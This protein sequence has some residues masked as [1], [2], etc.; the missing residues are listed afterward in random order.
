MLQHKKKYIVSITFLLILAGPTTA[1]TP[2]HNKDALCQSVLQC[3]TKQ[4]ILSHGFVPVRGFFR[5]DGSGYTEQY[6][7]PQVRQGSAYYARQV[8]HGLLCFATLGL[9]EIAYYPIE[10]QFAPYIFIEATYFNKHSRRIQ[11]LKI[12]TN[13]AGGGPAYEKIYAYRE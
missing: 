10:E 2:V 9:W 1:N 7:L 6:E 12:Y 13:P 3:R 5:Q 11:E 8:T 4:C